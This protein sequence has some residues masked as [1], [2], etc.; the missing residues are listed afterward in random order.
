MVKGMFV[1]NERDAQ[2]TSLST[3]VEHPSIALHSRLSGYLLII[4]KV[5]T[6]RI[7][8]VDVFWCDPGSLILLIDEK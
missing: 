2:L 3:T 1:I 7:L 8:G 5:A 4:P 6:V